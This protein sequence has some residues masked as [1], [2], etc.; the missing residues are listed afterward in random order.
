MDTNS[1]SY[2]PILILAC[3]FLVLISII[4]LR[5]IYPSVFPQYYLFVGLGIL[6][7]YLFSR[8]SFN[9][10][11][12]FSSHLYLISIV[13]L[14]IPLVTGQVTRGAI[15]WI[16]L[17]DLTVQPSEIVRPFLFLFFAK[18]MIDQ[19]GTKRLIKAV[20][21]S[22]LP[23]FLIIIQPSLGVAILTAAGFAGVVL[24]SDVKK[25]HLVALFLVFLTAVPLI[26]SLLAP[27]QKARIG[28]FIDPYSD[29]SGAGYNSIQSMISVGSGMITGRGLGK[30]VQ[31]QLAFLPEKHTDFIFA[32]IAEEMGFIGSSILLVCLIVLLL[33]IIHY[34]ENPKGPVERAFVCGIFLSMFAE[35]SIHVGMN[36]G[37]F[38]ITGV[39]LP[40]VS[41]GGSSLVATMMS[42]AMV[43]G[44]KRLY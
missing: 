30:G 31:T 37:L 2:D 33:R 9:I 17:G 28:A 36:M 40:L 8:I 41:A 16:P 4:V 38:P 14:F 29:P 23:L 24:A 39:P 5:S 6:V 20:V 19:T 25:K 35:I 11:S 42:V 43:T 32:A 13:L 34:V 27:Y 21:F 1:K 26:W 12:A 10:F 7:F 3:S 22:F 44:T 15:R 18:I